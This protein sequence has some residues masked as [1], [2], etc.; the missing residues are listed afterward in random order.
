MP[1]GILLRRAM[2]TIRAMLPFEH[3][4]SINLRFNRTEAGH[5]VGPGIEA[6]QA[7]LRSSATLLSS[8]TKPNFGLICSSIRRC[9]M[10][11]LTK[12]RRPGAHL[13]HARLIKRAPSISKGEPILY[14]SGF[15][16]RSANDEQGAA[17][18]KPADLTPVFSY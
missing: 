9:R 2:S 12:G 14:P 3:G 5:N 16:M 11:S 18:D 15:K 4:A 8:F 1:H 7:R 17:I 10:S 13:F 6:M